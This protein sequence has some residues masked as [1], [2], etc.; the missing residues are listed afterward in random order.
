MNVDGWFPYQWMFLFF[1]LFTVALGIVLWFFLPNSPMSARWLNERERVIAVERLKSNKNGV[2]NH[3]H[4]K[5]QVIEALTDY[6]VWMLVLAVFWHNITNSLQS[7]FTGL[8]INGFGYDTS[9]SAS[10]LP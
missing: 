7:N 5:A 6:Q 1:C 2:K 3:H 9:S 4:K 8:I 10:P